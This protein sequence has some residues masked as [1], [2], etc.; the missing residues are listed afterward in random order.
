MK[1]LFVASEAAPY[2]SSGGLGDVIGSLPKEL[3]KLGENL[4]ITVITPL[5]RST[6]ENFSKE[7]SEYKTIDFNL[8]WRKTGAK[9]YKL[10]QGSVSYVFVENN[11]YFDR[12]RLYGEYD[13]G[14]RFAFFS[15]SAIEFLRSESEKN[16]ILHAHDW[17]TA[18]SIVYLKRLYQHD[19]K[20]KDL[21][22][23]FTIHNIE[24]QGKFG[25]DI[26][27]D[28][29]GLND[30][31][32][33]DI[34]FD[35]C[36]NLMKSGI[37]LA[38]Y[39]TTVSPSYA[40]ELKYD[41]YSFGLSEIIKANEEKLYGI[42]NGIDYDIYSPQNDESLYKKYSLRNFRSGKTENKICLQRDIGLDVNAEIPLL[43]MITRLTK[44]K[45]IDLFL[46]IAREVLSEEVQFVI[47]G[48]GDYEYEKEIK[49][50]EYQDRRFKAIIG[51]NRELSHKIYAAGDIFL[52]PSKQEPCGLSQLIACSYGSV[53]IVRNV[54]GLKDTIIPYGC[55]NSNGF[56]FDNYNA[57]DFLSE[58]KKALDLYRNN[59]KEWNEILKR[60]MKAKHSWTNS[61]KEYLAIYKKDEKNK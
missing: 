11:Y 8:S 9:Y 36:I 51:F 16:D 60:S 6:R 39:V 14:E 55:D 54:G 46:H 19:E 15:M 13:D 41:F 25:L 32:R 35:G 2:S 48:S 61:A 52:M 49:I 50:L 47:L 28:V 20:L 4:S 12:D 40:D 1:I 34:E 57:H 18:L 23:V 7:L 45:G 53:P 30:N 38:D 26:L 44:Q 58:I 10:T 42:I 56:K 43:I 33:N 29:F 3:V 22:T 37:M 27:G 24:Y 59:K 21:K 5:Y 17:Q 31:V